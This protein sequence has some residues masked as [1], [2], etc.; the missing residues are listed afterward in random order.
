MPAQNTTL[1]QV[2]FGAKPLKQSA[3][4]ARAT[5][6]PARARG[7]CRGSHAHFGARKVKT[8]EF[9]LPA[10]TALPRQQGRLALHRHQAAGRIRAS[11]RAPNVSRPSILTAAGCATPR[12]AARA[13]MVPPATG[14]CVPSTSPAHPHRAAPTSQALRRAP[15]ECAGRQA[16][17]PRTCA[18]AAHVAPGA[19]SGAAC[20]RVPQP[21]GLAQRAQRSEYAARGPRPW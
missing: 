6:R 21:R 15:C 20:T 12:G 11:G 4:P 9:S 18:S 14:A 13:F 8:T 17:P 5:A 2:T 19:Q 1:L 10:L 16:A 7:P 3:H